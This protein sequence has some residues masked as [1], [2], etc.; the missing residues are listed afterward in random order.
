MHPQISVPS[1][2]QNISKPWTPKLI[3]TINNHEMKVAKIRGS[4][5]WHSHPNSDELFYVLN[6]S[7]TLEI[8]DAPALQLDKGDVFVV[9]RG[10]RHRPVSNDGA[11]ILM[12]ELE[13]TINTG[14]VEGSDLTVVP[15]DVRG[16]KETV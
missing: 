3:A 5:I 1:T 6:G 16:K 11:E 7:M 12:V 2:V 8:E 4:F 10:I 13:G 9:P 15:E 14:D